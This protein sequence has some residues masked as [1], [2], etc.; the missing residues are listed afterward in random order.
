MVE[1]RPAFVRFRSSNLYVLVTVSLSLFTDVSVE[2]KKKRSGQFN[3]YL[4]LDDGL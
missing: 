3:R 2:K 4:L 1:K